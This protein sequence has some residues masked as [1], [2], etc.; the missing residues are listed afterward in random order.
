VLQ[1]WQVAFLGPHRSGILNDSNSGTGANLIPDAERAPLVRKA[2][3]MMA[4]GQ[5]K[6][7]EVLKAVSDCGTQD[8]QRSEAL[9]TD[10]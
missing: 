2:F 5:Y 6:K 3:E 10:V 7:T 9:R 8:P 1:L 4:T